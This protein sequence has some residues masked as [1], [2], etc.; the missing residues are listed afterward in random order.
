VNRYFAAFIPGL[1]NAIAGLLGERLP[2][3]VIQKLLDGAVL[4]QTG[5]SYDKLNFF[6]FNNIFAVVDIME[7][8]PLGTLETHI[9]EIVRKRLLPAAEKLIAHNNQKIRTFRI[10]ISQENKPV[11]ID[12]KLRFAAEQYIA[13]ISGL[14]ADRSGPDTEFWFLYRSEGFSLFMKRL[15]L[16]PSWEKSLH[17]GELP[18]PLAWMLCHLGQLRYSDAVLDPFCGYG[19]IPQAAIKHFH[20]TQCIICDSNEKAAAY[21]ATRLKKHPDNFILH[22]AD[23]RSLTEVL[24]GKSIDVIITDP[25]W[26]CYRENQADQVTNAQDL[27]SELYAEMFSVFNLL[28]REN[29]RMVI[30]GG[31]TDDLINAAKGCFTLQKQ[32]P[33]LLSGK[34]AT[35][36]CFS[37]AGIRY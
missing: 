8:D 1:Q 37:K 9:T 19:S 12:E 4:F 33:I 6:C 34:K 28:L 32:I 29:G 35:I 13:K 14:K 27:P 10:V 15:T 5:C 23:F 17:P 26:G 30:L 18:P 20:I 25:P 22:K 16:R 36:F 3:A 24:P 2:D 11:A 21:T 31:R 7:H